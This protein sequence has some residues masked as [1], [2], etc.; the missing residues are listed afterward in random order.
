MCILVYTLGCTSVQYGYFRASSLANL[1]LHSLLLL[2]NEYPQRESYLFILIR[3]CSIGNIFCLFYFS[4][5]HTVSSRQQASA[6]LPHPCCRPQL[7]APS[8]PSLFTSISSN[9]HY[10]IPNL[11]CWHATTIQPPPP[12]P[13]VSTNGK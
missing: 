10:Y 5:I 1:F 2:R 8:Q 12:Y 9:S 13:H 3:Q 4:I 6:Y 11:D 7:A